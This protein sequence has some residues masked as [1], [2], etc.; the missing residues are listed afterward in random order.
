MKKR[1]DLNEKFLWL[2][3]LKDAEKQIFWEEKP[4]SNRQKTI[5]RILLIIALII[6]IG[7]GIKIGI[8]SARELTSADH[9]SARMHVHTALRHRGQT[10]LGRAVLH[11]E[12]L[13]ALRDHDAQA[14]HFRVH[15]S[16][17]VNAA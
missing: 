12:H 2:R 8:V 7:I 11:R 4:M 5:G 1:Y 17:Y 16:Q 9:D 13:N 14:V 15:Q 6:G 10:V 3:C